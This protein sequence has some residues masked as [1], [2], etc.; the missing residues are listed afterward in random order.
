MAKDNP[1]K[2][3]ERSHTN[4]AHQTGE[5]KGRIKQPQQTDEKDLPPSAEP[6]TH[7]RK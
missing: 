5:D 6:V 3:P 2:T 4:P 7:A 1:A